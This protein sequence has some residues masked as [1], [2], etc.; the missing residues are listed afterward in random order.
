MSV[1]PGPVPLDRLARMPDTT[2]PSPAEPAAD[3]VERQ[4][5]ETRQSRVQW[6]LA[7]SV[8][9]KDAV[10]SS[11]E[12]FEIEGDELATLA[13]TA[14]RARAMS[15]FGDLVA[16]GLG[17][18]EAHVATVRALCDAGQ[19]PAAR[20]FALGL[21]ALPDGP[22]LSRIGFGLVLHSMAEYPLAWAQL[23]TVDVDTLA[24][25][26]PVEAVTSAL[27]EGS[28]SAVAAARAVGAHGTAYDVTTLVE[29][30]GRFLATG[31]TDLATSLADRAADQ[32]ANRISARDAEVLTGLRR[33]THPSPSAGLRRARSRWPSWTTTSPTSTGP[34]ATSAT[35][36]RPWRCSATWPASATPSSP[37]PTAWASW[38][39]T[40]R[41]A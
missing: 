28:E 4:R 19:R 11:F 30:G 1:R 41:A 14:R 16:G 39:P 22:M 20:A 27:A 29:L 18:R 21:E 24:R 40:S 12:G 37:V 3:D 15:V 9:G 25:L 34:R 33:W 13:Q 6:R 7:Q 5:R 31:H 35:T 32:P 2:D 23:S 36:S 8:L 38:S 26:V 17:F 10:P